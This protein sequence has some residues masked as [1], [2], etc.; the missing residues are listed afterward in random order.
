[1]PAGGFLK[2]SGKYIVDGQGNEIILRGMGLGGWM[3]PEGYMLLTSDFAN[4]FWQM[5]NKIIDVVGP[6]KA[7]TFWTAYRENFV[8]RKDIERLAQQGFN[9][10]R[11]AMHWEHYMNSDGSLR[12]YGFTLT[13]SLLHRCAD[14]KI[15]LIL[16]LHAAP[17]GQSAQGISDYNPAYLSLWDS[18]T[19]RLLTV[20]LWK[21]LAERYKNEPW[22]G[23]YDLIN[24]TAWGLGTNNKPLRDLYVMIT[25][26]IRSVDTTH[27]IFIEGNSYA[28]DFTGLPPAWD[29]NLV[30]SFH[31]YWNKN[32]LASID[33]A[34]K[35]RDTT[36]RPLWL[37]ESG[38]N[39]NTWFTDAISMVEA[40]NIG[41]SWWTLKKFETVVGPYSVA[42]TP[43]Y[44]ALLNYWKGKA[45]KPPVDTAMKALMGMA[46]GLKLE[47]CIYHPDVI[48]AMM[49][50]PHDNTTTPFAANTIPGKVFLTNYDFGKYG[51][52]YKDVEYQNTG[53]GNWN[54]GWTYRNDGVDIEK[55]SDSITNGYC[56]T[57]TA[58]GEFLLYTVDVLQS[59]KYSI[60]LNVAAA[61]V[62]GVGMSWD[63]NSQVGATF[64]GTGSL[65]TWQ[66]Q[67]LGDVDLTAGKHTLKLQLYI[68]GFNLNY[69][70]FAY[71]GPLSVEREKNIPSEYLLSQ[72]YPNP[73][74][75]M[76]AI[77]YAIPEASKISLCVYDVLG[78]KVSTLVD[79]FK[80]PGMYTALFDASALSSGVY[81]YT[82][83]ANNFVAAKKLTVVK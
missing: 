64:A 39:S 36:N 45:S 66:S 41:W 67:S 40:N 42:V 59:G 9:S 76:T 83:T 18:E 35:L 47:N 30:W 22:V 5:K 7:D 11:L 14:N 8:Q 77:P 4:P 26:S 61:D 27:I 23:G 33:F 51:I 70:D 6:E 25:D 60:S 37:G 71:T 78:R 15:Y 72:N 13:D 55:C 73:F 20:K 80:S 79:E 62:G 52:A 63:G 53:R 17:G 74:N 50:Q 38:E 10:V 34:L 46:E 19:N 1:M 56:V 54:L 16:D 75:P 44:N 12:E 43:G 68:G 65:Q 2:V 48:D 81:L 3:L 28:N 82:L 69:I 49:R 31:K 29:S 57:H 24:E 58:T 21:K 32:D